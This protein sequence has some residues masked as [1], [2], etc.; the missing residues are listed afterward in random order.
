MAAMISSN[1][2]TIFTYFNA[3]NIPFYCSLYFPIGCHGI[4]TYRFSLL[5]F[6]HASPDKKA[7]PLHLFSHAILCVFYFIDECMMRVCL[8]E[9][10]CARWNVYCLYS[11][12]H[13]ILLEWQNFHLSSGLMSIEFGIL[14]LEKSRSI[15]SGAMDEMDYCCCIQAAKCAFT[16]LRGRKIESGRVRKNGSRCTIATRSF[17]YIAPLYRPLESRL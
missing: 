11:R 8:C 15:L 5:L 1:S 17:L 4:F 7:F 14:L 2:N 10:V 6:L 9:C 12:P 3:Q 13:F 16:I